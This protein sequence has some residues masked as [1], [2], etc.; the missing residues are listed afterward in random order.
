MS[1][2]ALPTATTTVHAHLAGPPAKHHQH[3]LHYL[4]LHVLPHVQA[5]TATAHECQPLSTCGSLLPTQRLHGSD[6][7]GGT[8]TPATTRPS[9]PATTPACTG[10]AT[11]QAPSRPPTAPHHRPSTPATLRNRGRPSKLHSARHRA[12][13][14]SPWRARAR[15]GCLWLQVKCDPLPCTWLL[16]CW[17]GLLLGGVLLSC[18]C[19]GL[20]LLLAAVG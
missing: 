7:R 15:R 1:S 12:R 3:N 6:L 8:T 2:S 5:S 16:P 4:S 9:P 10:A 17:L 13:R 18:A 20:L 11:R 19:T 14:S